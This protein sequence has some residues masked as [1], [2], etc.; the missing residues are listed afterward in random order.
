MTD[1][2]YT[3]SSANF[4]MGTGNDTSTYAN[5]IETILHRGTYILN[6][7]TN[8]GSQIDTGVHRFNI[9]TDGLYKFIVSFAITA[10]GNNINND[11]NAV[12]EVFIN[13]SQY[14]NSPTNTV[15][16]NRRTLPYIYENHCNNMHFEYLC[17]LYA[18]DFIDIRGR[19]EYNSNVNS[20][21][22]CNGATIELVK[23]S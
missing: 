8:S 20:Y 17:R 6:T 9:L 12:F 2:S 11:G 5:V 21:A 3:D 14:S 10:F 4:P 15:L 19:Q 13:G 23:I 1:P 18:G 16:L 22:I 7:G